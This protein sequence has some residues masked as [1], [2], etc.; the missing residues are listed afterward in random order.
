M[1][2]VLRKPNIVGLYHPVFV[3]VEKQEAPKYHPDKPEIYRHLHGKE[4]YLLSCYNIEG[5]MMV[6]VHMEGNYSLTAVVFGYLPGER[7]MFHAWR[8]R[9]DHLVESFHAMTLVYRVWPPDDEKD[10]R[11]DEER[12]IRKYR[13][14]EDLVEDLQA[15]TDIQRD[16]LIEENRDQ[17]QE[18]ADSL[19]GLQEENEYALEEE[20]TY[21]PIEFWMYGDAAEL[22]TSNETTWCGLVTPEWNGDLPWSM[23]DGNG[24][25]WSYL[26]L[27]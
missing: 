14:T 27:W 12:T 23:A 3:Y 9:Y 21:E 19:Q 22:R 26:G 18:L 7:N 2:A 6:A 11:S 13:W 20:G 25:P 15:I 4:K 8:K 5:V 17:L 16:P 10:H 24:F 1:E